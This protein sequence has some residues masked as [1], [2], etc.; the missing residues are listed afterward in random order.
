MEPSTI[1]RVRKRFVEVDAAAALRR[2]APA[3][4]RM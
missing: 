4:T 1:E 2:R 3:Q